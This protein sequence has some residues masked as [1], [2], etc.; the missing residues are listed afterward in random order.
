MNVELKTELIRKFATAIDSGRPL[1]PGGDWSEDAILAA[2]VA[3]Y[4]EAERR[5]EQLDR[6]IMGIRSQES[7]QA[8]NLRRALGQL[9]QVGTDPDVRK[10]C[11]EIRTGEALP[12]SLVVMVDDNPKT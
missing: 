9:A 6:S 2:V 10:S 8:E 3:T 12:A 4:R 11:D 5:F 1:D 7:L